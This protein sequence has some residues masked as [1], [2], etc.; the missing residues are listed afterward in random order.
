MAHKAQFDLQALDVILGA[1]ADINA[2][3]MN[4]ETPLHS[5]VMH[6]SLTTLELLINRNADTAAVNKYSCP[7]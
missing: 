6:G 7:P 5:C 3:N 4:G 1:G 2:T